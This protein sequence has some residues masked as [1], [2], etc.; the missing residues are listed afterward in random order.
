MVVIFD[1]QDLRY[2][3]G[4]DWESGTDLGQSVVIE[5]KPENPYI[6]RVPNIVDV[7]LEVKN[8]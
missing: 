2:K 8:G 1:L 6:H 7:T 5:L 3:R 4:L